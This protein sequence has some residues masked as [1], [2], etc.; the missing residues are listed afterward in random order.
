M[1]T[2]KTTNTTK[3]VSKKSIKQ[4]EVLDT[5]TTKTSSSK[6]NTKSDTKPAKI[7]GKELLDAVVNS[8]FEAKG[9]DIVALDVKATFGLSDYFVIVSARSD[10]QVQGICN[11]VIHDI[12]K[13][14][15]VKPLSS[16]GLE[17]GHWALIDY[18][19][20]VV[21]VFY[22]QVRHEYDLE[23]LW[24]KAKKVKLNLPDTE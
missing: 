19:D 17:K 6:E 3:R 20:I 10:R 1:V 11:R 22:E 4:E 8:C 14:Y 9:S 12:A 24:K 18:G 21:H 16:E 2:K 15:R 5:I 13:H 7:S 23:A